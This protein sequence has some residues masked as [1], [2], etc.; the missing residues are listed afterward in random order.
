[1]NNAC[2]VQYQMDPTGSP[3]VHMDELG[4]I[5]K[6]TLRSL[7]LKANKVLKEASQH[8]V[9]ILPLVKEQSMN[10]SSLLPFICM[11]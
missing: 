2:P 3:H 6:S 9:E 5:I 11:I 10:Q 4:D 7:T 8:L 1:M